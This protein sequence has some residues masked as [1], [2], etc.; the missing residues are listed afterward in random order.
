M[1]ILATVLKNFTW[2][3]DGKAD[4]SV[5]VANMETLRDAMDEIERLRVSTL[6]DLNENHPVC[7]TW[8]VEAFGE[9]TVLDK[10]YRADMQ[11]TH[12]HIV[13]GGT[14]DVDT[15]IEI[16]KN[17]TDSL[18]DPMTLKSSENTGKIR[19]GNVIDYETVSRFDVISVKSS[20]NRKMSITMNF[21]DV[22]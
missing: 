19:I 6:E 7:I 8:A 13:A 20:S 3:D 21:G 2:I 14:G 11:L 22:E 10:S 16:F 9:E 12:A 5:L 17:G 15:T 4:F 1:I 18:C